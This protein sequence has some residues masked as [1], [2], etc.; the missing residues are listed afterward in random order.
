MIV[1][2]NDKTFHLFYSHNPAPFSRYFVTPIEVRV[3]TFIY[4]TPIIDFSICNTISVYVTQFQLL[5]SVLILPMLL[6]PEKFTKFY[7]YGVHV[8]F[9]NVSIPKWPETINHIA[10]FIYFK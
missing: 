8:Y 1:T 10:D 6:N 5:S 4:I 7:L 2:Q 9:D 3:L